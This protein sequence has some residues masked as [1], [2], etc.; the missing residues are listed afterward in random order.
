[1]PQRFERIAAKPAVRN[2]QPCIRGTRATV[3]RALD[4]QMLPLEAA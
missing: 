2:G 4:D 1:M 3:R